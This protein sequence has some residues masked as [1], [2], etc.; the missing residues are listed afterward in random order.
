M[1]SRRP[2][3]SVPVALCAL[4]ACGRLDFARVAPGADATTRDD[5]PA[6]AVVDVRLGS[7]SHAGMTWANKG[8][9]VDSNGDPIVQVG[10]DA[11]TNAYNGDTAATAVL[12][13]LC[14]S[15]TGLPA[16]NPNTF[17]D[18]LYSGWSGGTVGVT[19]AV[20]GT[21]LESLAI[22]DALCVEHVGAGY[23]MAEF[24]DGGGNGWNFVAR[25]VLPGERMWATI[26]DQL[27]NPW[28]P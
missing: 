27:A 9:Y 12:P 20:S 17:Y 6:G 2:H 15:I 1:R 23:R 5:G 25:G 8:S 19:P 3:A 26:N 22:A 11:M 28:S 10:S 24:H 13:V 18:P 7:A 16:P 21:S 14:I 4:A